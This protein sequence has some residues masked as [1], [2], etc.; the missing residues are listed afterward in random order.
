[1]ILRRRFVVR[2]R[3]CWG[4][5][6][7]GVHVLLFLYSHILNKPLVIKQGRKKRRTNTTYVYLSCSLRLN[8]LLTGVVVAITG[9]TLKG[10]SEVE[11]K[12]YQ[13][14]ENTST[15]MSAW[16]LAL[17]AGLWAYDGWDNVSDISQVCKSRLL[18]Q[19]R[20]TTSLGS[21]RTQ[22]KTYPESSTQPCLWS[23]SAMC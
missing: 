10:K 13:L 14:F 17:Y 20:Q 21:S 23:S 3:R 12:P 1:M 22:L 6:I 16:A 9:K 4:S 2:H 19:S 7:V 15:D 11:W 8:I 18:T 5:V